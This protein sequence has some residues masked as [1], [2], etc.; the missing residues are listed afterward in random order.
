VQEAL[1]SFEKHRH[2]RMPVYSDRIDNI[3]GILE[4][5]DLLTAN[6]ISEKIELYISTAHYASE[7]QSLED[8]MHDMKNE[9][10]EMVV[11]VDEHGGAVGILTFEDIVEEIVGE[12]SDEFDFES[13]PYKTL[14]GSSWSVQAN[15]E[16]QSI[17]E[18]LRLELP[19]GNYETL[20]GFLLQQFGR[21][22]EVRDE[23]YFHTPA[24]FYKFVIKN[25]TERH[26][27][28]VLIEKIDS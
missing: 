3:I 21:I 6:D 14:S 12:I 28:M 4:T 23:L 22:P 8:L 18:N 5:S 17:N 19:E 10:I 11:V 26:I 25:A 15:M 7:T 27:K 20:S 9:D 2:S 24:G 13:L 16:I 1:E